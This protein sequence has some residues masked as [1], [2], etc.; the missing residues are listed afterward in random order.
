[1]YKEAVRFIL[2]F[3]LR[4]L[5]KE[6]R[7]LLAFPFDGDVA[8]LRFIISK[9]GANTDSGK[10]TESVLDRGFQGK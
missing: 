3:Q 2:L 7:F 5:P 10:Q 1:V 4:N 8:R 9:W 6:N